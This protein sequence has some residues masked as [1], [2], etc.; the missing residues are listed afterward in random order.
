MKKNL[1]NVG[2]P[3]IVEEFPPLQPI[4]SSDRRTINYNRQLMT[5][6][7]DLRYWYLYKM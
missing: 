3:T 4:P 2:V 7:K 5:T 1:I 6:F